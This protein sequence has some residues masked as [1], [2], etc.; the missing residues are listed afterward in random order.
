MR[1]T[2]GEWC[3]HKFQVPPEGVRPTKDMVRE[4]IFSKLQH[5]IADCR[6]LDLFAGS[7]SLGIESLSRGAKSACWVE[8]DPVTYRTLKSNVKA[9]A[10]EK[11][12]RD[13]IHADVWA[14][15]KRRGM[16]GK[17]NLVFADPPY[18]KDGP[19]GAGGLLEILAESSW[20]DEPALLV[21]EQ[22]RR[23]EVAASDK[24][25]LIWQRGYG[26]ARI[27]IYRRRT[28]EPSE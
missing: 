20:V 19:G 17:F 15:L 5:L 23:E 18:T 28:T 11:K 12:L 13:C 7:G 9:I 22:H 1:I 16:Q 25:E 10:G 21:Y 8:K 2:G 6:V 4:A 24:W 14:L 26:V 3:R 27:I